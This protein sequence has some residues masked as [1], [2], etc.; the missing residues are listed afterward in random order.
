MNYMGGQETVPIEVP[1]WNGRTH[2][3]LHWPKHGFELLHHVS[4]VSDWDNKREVANYYYAEMASLAK[5]MSGCTHALV[6][7][8]ISRNPAQAQV[9][10]DYAPI[11]FVHSDF[12]DNYAGLVTE[13]YLREDPDSVRA[14]TAAG[15][16]ASDVAR[17]KRMLI[18]QFWRN[19]GAPEMD[20]PIAFCDA[21]SVPRQDMQA[22]HVPSYAG[23]DFAFDTYAVHPPPSTSM[24]DWYVFPH[25]Q[26][27]EVVAFRTFD[28]DLVRTGKTFWTPH[29][30]FKDPNVPADAPARCSIE[31]RATCLFD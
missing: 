22:I 16:Q 14:L 29:S 9:H 4:A 28:S 31:I 23:S 15:L 30:A 2:A 1:I 26:V 25:M 20:L 8:H 19:V 21:Q 7:S 27:D 13:R 3:G 6:S 24:H 5:Q 11:Q 12:T 18:L 10:Q 17:A